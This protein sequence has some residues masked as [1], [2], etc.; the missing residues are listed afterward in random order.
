MLKI[1]LEKWDKNKGLLEEKL[2]NM[3]MNYQYKDLVKLTF[4]TVY[5]TGETH[6]WNE[7]RL[8]KTIGGK[9][10]SGDY[11]FLLNFGFDDENVET[12]LITYVEYGSCSGCDTLLRIIEWDEGKKPDE[13]QLKDLMLLCKDIITNTVKPFNK[14]WN[15]KEGFD[16]VEYEGEQK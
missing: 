7:V 16:E 14:G 13:N 2:R 9:G 5:N 11:V 4:D 1:L 3:P 12:M 15:Y 8:V 6:E 10:Y